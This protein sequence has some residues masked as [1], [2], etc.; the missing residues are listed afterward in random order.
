MGGEEEGKGMRREGMRRWK[1]GK[2][3]G[4]GGARPQIC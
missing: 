4:R 2:M 1:G 3:E